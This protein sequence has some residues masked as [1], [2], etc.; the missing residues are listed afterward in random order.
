[1]NIS[2]FDKAKK[3]ADIVQALTE[4]VKIE[5]TLGTNEVVD[6]MEGNEHLAQFNKGAAFMNKLDDNTII[7]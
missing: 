7:F 6:P 3:K 2:G 4:G 1:M 5:N